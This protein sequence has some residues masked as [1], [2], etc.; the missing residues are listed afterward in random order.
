[1]EQA[2]A[3]TPAALGA[4]LARGTARFDLPLVR[5]GSRA[6]RLGAFALERW[7]RLRFEATHTSPRERALEL[8][9]LAEN[10]CALHGL[11]AQLRGTLP[12]GPC[13]LVANHLSYFD[14]VV[15]AAHTPLTAIAKTDV[16][17][18]PLVGDALRRLGTTFVD[19]ED[20]MSGALALRRALRSLQSGVSVLVFPEGTTTRG[21]QVLPF[22][23]GIF[24]AARRAGVPVIPVALRY[25]RPEVA[26]VGDDSFLPHYVRAMAQPC[27]RV[28]V[29]YLS[30][31][32]TE[33]G[34]RAEGMAEA[35]RRAIARALTTQK[36][37]QTAACARAQRVF[38][39]SA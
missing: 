1:M 17:A 13:V 16:A 33:R 12:R 6:A 31:L 26:W 9:W 3:K 15:L 7:S 22:R 38:L 8:S 39:A 24:G 19:R 25:D 2:L 23:R 37:S 32:T 14:P 29:E 28:T 21:D 5:T 18:W 27:T 10:L 4:L 34:Q 36:Q 35:A 11:R 30:P 20:A